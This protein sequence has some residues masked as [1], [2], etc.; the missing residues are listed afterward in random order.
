[1]EQ[2]CDVIRRASPGPAELP[3]TIGHLVQ[4]AMEIMISEQVLA[5][6]DEL[7][8]AIKTL[9]QNKELEQLP[10]SR[11][12][13]LVGFGFVVR[14]TKE[15][16]SERPIEGL[17]EEER[18]AYTHCVGLLECKRCHSMNTAT[19]GQ[20][21]E[22]SLSILCKDC[23]LVFAASV[24]RD[25][26]AK[27]KTPRKQKNRL[28]NLSDAELVI[29]ITRAGKT[30]RNYNNRELLLKQATALLPAKKVRRK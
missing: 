22:R 27:V 4:R 30:V 10:R 20:M 13:D 24:K 7:W 23:G 16:A 2:I 26:V 6:Q 17:T 12:E 21:Q 15:G 14:L 19:N 3:I 9:M 8:L 5:T 11:S 29:F 25:R 18:A 28:E 1:M